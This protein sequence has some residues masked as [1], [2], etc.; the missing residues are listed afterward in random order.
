MEDLRQHFARHGLR[1]TAQRE[2][3]YRALAATKSHP[4]AEELHALVRA[5]RPGVS[6]ATV[7]NALDAFTRRG[8]ARR[9]AGLPDSTGSE[10]GGAPARFDA[11]TS[12]HVHFV[13]DDGRVRDVPSDLGERILA[14]L[15]AHVLEDIERRM[16]VSV[17]RV[18]VE[19][20]GRAV[21]GGRC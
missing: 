4:T 6:L 5:R 10:R 8:L 19:F 18:S 2:E 21:G 11:D 3:V 9:F 1:F 14:A 7:Y 16:G 20:A 15:P 17:D 13:G 12:D